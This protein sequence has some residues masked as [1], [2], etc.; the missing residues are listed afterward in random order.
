MNCGSLAIIVTR[1]WLDEWS[2]NPA[3][4]MRLIA[5]MF[6]RAMGLPDLLSSG[7]QDPLHWEQ[8]GWG[9]S[10]TIQLHLVQI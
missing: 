1:L 10:L 2:M 8:S 5:T 9:I 7:Y 4:Y 6:N 3:R